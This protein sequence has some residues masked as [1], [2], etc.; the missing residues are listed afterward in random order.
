VPANVVVIGSPA[1]VV[2][3]L[4]SEGKAAAAKAAAAQQQAVAAAKPLAEP[5]L[6]SE[7]P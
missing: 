2:R 7:Q 6:A 4:G 3:M 1:R 5:K